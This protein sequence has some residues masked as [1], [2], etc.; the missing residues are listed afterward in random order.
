[1]I[2]ARSKLSEVS[3]LFAPTPSWISHFK[4][5]LVANVAGN[6]ESAIHN[7]ESALP[8]KMSN[9][10]EK[11]SNDDLNNLLPSDTNGRAERT[12]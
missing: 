4:V 12:V 3:R 11:R 10:A 9:N 6:N 5:P 1:M 8:S 2:H 7:H